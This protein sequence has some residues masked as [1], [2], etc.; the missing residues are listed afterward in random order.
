M[1]A[2]QYPPSL[3]HAPPGDERL[4][5]CLLLLLWPG[6]ESSRSISAKPAKSQVLA[7]T[8]EGPLATTAGDVDPTHHVTEGQPGNS[9]K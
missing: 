3:C 6:Q 7:G 2:D 1:Q 9:V 5:S 4:L 8:Q